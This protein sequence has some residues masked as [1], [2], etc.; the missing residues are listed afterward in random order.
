MSKASLVDQNGA[1]MNFLSF[2]NNKKDVVVCSL[3]GLLAKALKR[4]NVKDDVFLKTL[5][6]QQVKEC[7]RKGNFASELAGEVGAIFDTPPST[8]ETIVPTA[9]NPTVW[10]LTNGMF[11]DRK[12]KA[13]RDSTLENSLDSAVKKIT[14]LNTAEDL[15]FLLGNGLLFGR[16]LVNEFAQD[17]LSN[18]VE[19]L[20]NSKGIQKAINLV[21]GDD[22]MSMLI[23]EFRVPDWQQLFVKLAAKQVP[24]R[25]LKILSLAKKGTHEKAD[26]SKKAK[27][28]H[29]HDKVPCVCCDNLSYSENDAIGSG[30]FGKCYKGLYRRNLPVVIKVFKR[31]TEKD[32]LNE[33][34]AIQ[35]IQGLEHHPCLPFLIGVSIARPHHFLLITQFHGG[36]DQ[37]YTIL[38]A[39][40][41]DVVSTPVQ[42]FNILI[43]L[44]GIRT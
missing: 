18:A 8:P 38:S 37:A 13:R 4:K 3:F 17:T 16:D 7:I 2:N 14:E 9:N 6:F 20:I 34:R 40:E 27:K 30:S 32:V 36:Q 1:G 15:G 31:S 41:S 25:G 28:Q 29:V 12:R 35:A 10:K 19:V 43:Q 22:N 26:G 11:S 21:I 42:W 24:N 39:T 44:S 33:A 23:K 5:Q